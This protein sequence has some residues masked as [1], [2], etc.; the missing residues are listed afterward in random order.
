MKIY[1]K[2]L[3]NTLESGTMV[4]K[5][6]SKVHLIL[7]NYR[8]EWFFLMKQRKELYLFLGRTALYF[9]IFLGL[10]LLL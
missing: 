8:N 6:Y 3:K 2:Q 7:K 4:E 10:L 1:G 9:L 5:Y